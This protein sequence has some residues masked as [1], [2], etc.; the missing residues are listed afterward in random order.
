MF[1]EPAAC[2]IPLQKVTLLRWLALPYYLYCRR[3]P[4]YKLTFLNRYQMPILMYKSSR[5]IKKQQQAARIV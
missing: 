5:Y 2:I 3:L 1:A 4:P